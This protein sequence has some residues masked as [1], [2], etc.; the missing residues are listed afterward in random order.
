MINF[1]L[2]LLALDA[3]NYFL[4]SLL[5]ILY[6]FFQYSKNNNNKISV[7]FVEKIGF[8][9][10]F[11]FGT[12]FSLDKSNINNTSILS[13][14]YMYLFIPLMTYIC[15]YYI[16]LCNEK[17]KNNNWT[18]NIFFIVLGCG[19]HVLLNMFVNI[20]RYR[21]ETIDFFTKEILAATN[22]GSIST[23]V[24]S[25]GFCFI[26]SRSKLRK[27]IG[28]VLVTI[29]FIYALVLG[30]RTQLFI[31]IIIIFIQ[32]T[33][34]IKELKKTKRSKKI[35]L[36]YFASL[37]CLIFIFIGYNL[38][39]LNIKTKIQETNLFERL[40]DT[41]TAESDS[42]RFRLYKEGIFS[43][44]EYP[45]GKNPKNGYFHNFWLD[46]GRVSGIFLF[47]ETIVISLLFVKESIKIYKNDR[48]DFEFRIAVIGVCFGI[49][50][51]FF[52]EPIMEGYL[53]LF[54]KFCLFFGLFESINK[55]ILGKKIGSDNYE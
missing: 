10:L 25:L 39:I 18:K 19:I 9:L 12:L 26:I 15:G 34:Y 47:F 37:I 4:I 49:L 5:I 43:L 31:A 28:L 6:C 40:Q 16:C 48:F 50:C 32:F 1:L 29:S 55:N 30:T 44:I 20:G 41:S 38:N 35:F 22:L 36:V 46:V 13:C 23:L 42:Y 53:A 21:W 51:N 3:F 2:T 17:E 45:A 11:I 14:L 33:L 7:S 8:I 52:V 54:Y 27:Y 24:F